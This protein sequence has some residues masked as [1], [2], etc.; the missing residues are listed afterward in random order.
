MTDHHHAWLMPTRATVLSFLRQLSSSEVS[1]DKSPTADQM[2]FCGRRPVP[3][4]L[5]NNVPTP[6]IAPAGQPERRFPAHAAPGAAG[7]D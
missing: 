3:V 4:G 1:V 2:A 7:Q 5:R 6:L